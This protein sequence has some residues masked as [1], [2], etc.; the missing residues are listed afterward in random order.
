M[1]TR[2]SSYIMYYNLNPD[3][4]KLEMLPYRVSTD[5]G[6]LGGYNLCVDGNRK[7]SNLP[8]KR[9]IPLGG[10]VDTCVSVKELMYADNNSYVALTYNG[11]LYCIGKNELWSPQN[12]SNFTR[13]FPLND[14]KYSR[15]HMF[16]SYD[17]K[18]L[19][20]TGMVA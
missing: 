4:P 1:A 8:E 16:I 2:T 19:L 20:I 13:Y 9:F 17:T 18:G 6:V 10:T 5:I 12:F 11:S 7:I 14:V 15:I 3:L